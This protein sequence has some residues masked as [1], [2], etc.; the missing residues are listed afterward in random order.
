MAFLAADNGAQGSVKSSAR[1][2]RKKTLPSKATRSLSSSLATAT[3]TTMVSVARNSP[4]GVHV[5]QSHA[6][7]STRR[8]RVHWAGGHC[9]NAAVRAAICDGRT[10]ADM[11]SFAV[12]RPLSTS[13]RFGV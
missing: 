3:V 1:L 10:K 9:G 13:Y 12:C 6:A 2:E 4:T 7:T 11:L 8:R 5:L